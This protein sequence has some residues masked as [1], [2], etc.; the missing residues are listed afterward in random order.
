MSVKA[1]TAAERETDFTVNVQAV[2][3]DSSRCLT[4]TVLLSIAQGE[5]TG[6]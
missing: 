1:V 2:S 4:H 6:Q 3:A 5:D